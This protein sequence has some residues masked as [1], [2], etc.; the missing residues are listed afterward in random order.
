M[1]KVR[2]GLHALNDSSNDR[3]ADLDRACDN[4]GL[5]LGK[6]AAEIDGQLSTLQGNAETLG[7]QIGEVAENA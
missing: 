4:L 2:D 6:T 7:R 3:F 5:T 1:V